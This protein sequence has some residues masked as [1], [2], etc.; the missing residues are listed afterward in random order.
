MLKT[1]SVRYWTV[2]AGAVAAAASLVAVG[3][4]G[5]AAADHREYTI[6][7]GHTYSLGESN[8]V[9]CSG[10]ITTNVRT[11]HNRPRIS[12]VTMGWAPYFTAPCSVVAVVNW[13]NVDSGQHGSTPTRLTTSTRGPLPPPITEGGYVEIPTAPGRMVFTITT[14]SLNYVAAPPVEVTVPG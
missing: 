14:T 3:A 12:L 5:T 8:N 11:P 4:T 2:R 10:Q 7:P 6:V 1:P 9:L 13:H